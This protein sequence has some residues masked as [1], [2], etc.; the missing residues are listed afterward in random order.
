MNPAPDSTFTVLIIDDDLDL[1]PF[2]ADAVRLLTP[3]TVVTA[4]NGILG[5][6][7]FFESSPH[8]VV[9]DVKMPEIDG[10]QF[11][12]AL[13]GDPRT[14]D[15]PIIMLTALGHE[16]DRFSGLASGADKYLQ[17]P[18]DPVDLVAAIQEVIQ[19]GEADRKERM[20]HLAESPQPGLPE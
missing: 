5:L 1:L 10:Y 4:E 19:L 17:K 12:R 14:A 8:C 20:K 2:L 18:A 11:V 13:R 3:Y 6:E 16:K 15:T 9:V 7:Q